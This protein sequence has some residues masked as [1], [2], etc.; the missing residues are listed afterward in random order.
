MPL[1]MMP[2]KSALPAANAPAPPKGK[3]ALHVR[4]LFSHRRAPQRHPGPGAGV[5]EVRNLAETCPN[6]PPAQTSDA[7]PAPLQHVCRAARHHFAAARFTDGRNLLLGTAPARA[8]V[9]SAASSARA[10]GGDAAAVRPAGGYAFVARE[11]TLG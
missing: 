6:A 11:T 4:P 3:R 7:A 1:P 8:V 5:A 9:A 2:P 10:P